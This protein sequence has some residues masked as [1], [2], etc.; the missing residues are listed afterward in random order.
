MPSCSDPVH[1]PSAD[2][3]TRGGVRRWRWA[4]AVASA[5]V[6]VACSADDGEDVTATEPDQGGSSTSTDGGGVPACA[7]DSWQDVEVGD[8]AFR[9]PPDVVDQEVQGI[10]SLVGQYEGGGLSV[11]FDYGIYSTSFDELDEY[12]PTETTVEVDGLEGRLL[13]ADVSSS[14]GGWDGDH[15]VALHL[16]VGRST[17]MGDTALAMWIAYDDPGL[18][19]QA[20]CIT[21][22]V[23]IGS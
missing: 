16:P 22:T 14:G 3:L 21:E 7:D 10:D 17:Q 12:G 9:L 20:T 5:L 8:L 19:A 6:L 2:A 18:E 1:A 11:A 4:V 23:E 13:V 15:L